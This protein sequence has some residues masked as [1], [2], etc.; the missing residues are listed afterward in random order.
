M[1]K[2]FLGTEGFQIPEADEPIPY[3]KA[4]L[5]IGDI[6]IRFDLEIDEHR[7]RDTMAQLKVIKGIN[8]FIET[9]KE[10]R[11]AYPEKPYDN[12]KFGCK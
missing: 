5:L 9:E 2:I 4:E 6:K 10:I 7:D 3:D 12:G 11:L 1:K 8:V